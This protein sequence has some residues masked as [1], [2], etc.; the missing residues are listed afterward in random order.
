MRIQV[1]K[2]K[3]KRVESKCKKLNQNENDV[4][5][6]F[7]TD[8]GQIEKNSSSNKGKEENKPENG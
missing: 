1:T 4:N 7:S 6:T 8:F 3:W 2:L 5:T